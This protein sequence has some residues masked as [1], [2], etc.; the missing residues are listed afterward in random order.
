MFYSHDRLFD[1]PFGARRGIE[2]PMRSGIYG[3]FPNA[4]D[5]L[6][7]LAQCDPY[8]L[9]EQLS[10]HVVRKAARHQVTMPRGD[11]RMGAGDD[12]QLRID[13]AKRIL[14]V[15]RIADDLARRVERERG[16]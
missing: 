6:G 11:D 9:L 1:T 5:D 13:A 7:R 16:S 14:L 3:E 2:Q 4:A 15:S 10:G 8:R 12:V